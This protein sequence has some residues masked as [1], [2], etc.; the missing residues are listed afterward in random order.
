MSVMSV[1]VFKIAIFQDWDP[2]VYIYP[3]IFTKSLCNRHEPE[4]QSKATKVRNCL[5]S[6]DMQKQQTM[7]KILV[8]WCVRNLGPSEMCYKTW[9]TKTK[10]V[11]VN[12][13]ECLDKVNWKNIAASH[14]TSNVYR[15]DSC[16]LRCSVGS[17]NTTR[18]LCQ[19]EWLLSG[20][21][22]L[23]WR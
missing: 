15:N 19:S 13:T 17:S 11:V 14:V 22:R 8:K 21:M 5:R 10:I 9:L 12:E 20:T 1:H 6:W 4:K 3:P 16:I 2:T 23:L 7:E 18:Y